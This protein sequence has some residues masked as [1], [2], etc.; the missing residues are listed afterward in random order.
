[1]LMRSDSK[2]PDN[3]ASSSYVGGIY[4]TY[5]SQ[6]TFERVSSQTTYFLNQIIC[7]FCDHTQDKE[8]MAFLQEIGPDTLVPCFSV[9][10]KEK[11]NDVD[12]CNA[13]NKAIFN[14]LCHSTDQITARRTPM[15]VTS[16]TLEHHK[17]S[18][19][20]ENLKKKLGVS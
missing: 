2:N 14:D 8:A 9:N 17:H 6:V 19:A 1:M 16:S 7:H 5:V 10:L 20:L 18:K 15:L 11:S 3:L 12:R 13:I 4:V